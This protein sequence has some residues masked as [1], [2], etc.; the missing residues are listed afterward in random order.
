M[1]CLRALKHCVERF[2]RKPDPKLAP[3][4]IKSPA[5]R[6]PRQTIPRFLGFIGKYPSLRDWEEGHLESRLRQL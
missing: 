5:T 6:V 1:L 4:L 2:A 3:A